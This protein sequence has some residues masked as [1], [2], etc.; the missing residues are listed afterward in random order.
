MICKYL[1]SFSSLPFHLDDSFY[2]PLEAF[3]FDIVPFVYVCVCFLCLWNQIHKNI[4]KIDVNKF[5]ICA[6][7]LEF[8][9]VKSYIQVI[10]YFQLIFMM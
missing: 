2:C 9:G 8:Y 7:F 4:A 3:E 1:L 5:T 10:F 6:F